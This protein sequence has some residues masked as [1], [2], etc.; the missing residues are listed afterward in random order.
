MSVL[1]QAFGAKSAGTVIQ[2]TCQERHQRRACPARCGPASLSTP[3]TCVLSAKIG[4]PDL[5]R[6]A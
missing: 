4:F 1:A 3:P 2:A 6:K 5:T